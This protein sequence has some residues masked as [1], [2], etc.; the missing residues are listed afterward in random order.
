LGSS[1]VYPYKK[2]ISPMSKPPLQTANTSRTREEAL[3]WFVRRRNKGFAAQE[4]QAFQT[5]LAANA[6]HREAFDR[7]S[8]EWQAFD[9][10]PQDM[11]SLLQRNLAYDQAMEAASSAGA[12][13]AKE[14]KE[15]TTQPAVVPSA[16]PP[17]ST[18]RRVLA[19]AFAVA[20]LAAVTGGTGLLAWNHWQAQQAQPVFTQAFSTQRGQQIEVPLPDGSNLRLDTATRVE[21][22]Y[23]RQHREVKLLDGQAVFAVQADAQRPFQVLAGPVRVSVVGTKFSVR[24][25][26]EVPGSAGV[27]VAVGEG[28]VRVQRIAAGA[29]DSAVLLTAR[30]QIASD[31]R[32]VLSA[33]SPVATVDFAPWREHRLSFDNLRLDQA[34]AELARYSDPQL[35]VH[36]PAVAALP[37]TGV[38]DPRDMA[39]FKRVLPAALPVR[40][41]P[42]S[43]GVAEVVSAR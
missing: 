9:E 22:A 18:R 6:A 19:P 34:L 7:W 4:E 21:V 12:A 30:Q 25:T 14:T 17:G 32:G 16:A 37:I 35:L 43:G 15:M 28:K 26:P 31:A 39:T 2:R 10:I 11:R 5:W 36:D 33:V 42:L 27:Q 24:H 1:H 23:Y 8:G 3:D 29:D 13:R 38:F 40:L 41:K 20:A